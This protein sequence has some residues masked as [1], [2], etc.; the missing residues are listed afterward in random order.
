MMSK[1]ILNYFGPIAKIEAR[2][3]LDE[4]LGP[5]IRIV[6]LHMV[7]PTQNIFVAC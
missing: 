2:G 7:T 5:P 6:V 4:W 1:S 3:S